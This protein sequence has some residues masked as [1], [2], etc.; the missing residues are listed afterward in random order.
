MV[1]GKPQ[2]IYS[3]FGVLKSN[4]RIGVCQARITS[5]AFKGR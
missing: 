2:I 3:S 5:L 1:M 4:V